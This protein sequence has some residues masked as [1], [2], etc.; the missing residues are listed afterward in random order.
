MNNGYNMVAAD[1]RKKTAFKAVL[2]WLLLP[3]FIFCVW[4]ALAQSVQR[5]ATGCTVLDRIPFGAR[6]SASDQNNPGAHPA[7]CKMCII[8]L[9]GVKR[10]V[11]GVDHPR[12]KKEYSCTAT[13][14]LWHHGLLHG[15]LCLSGW[16]KLYITQFY[17]QNPILKHPQPTF[18]PQCEWPSFTP[19]QNNKQNYNSVYLNLYIFR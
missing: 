15:E 19:I 6:L 11:G 3:K 13:P 12:L 5:L 10:P 7:S 4:S 1:G 2:E 18:L 8:T 14:R 9:P 17:P 16:V